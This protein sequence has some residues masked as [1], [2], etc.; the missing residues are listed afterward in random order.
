MFIREICPSQHTW[1]EAPPSHSGAFRSTGPPSVP[2]SSPGATRMSSSQKRRLQPMLRMHFQRGWIH[3]SSAQRPTCQ[4]RD[5]CGLGGFP[6]APGTPSGTASQGHVG[7]T[8]AAMMRQRHGAREWASARRDISGTPGGWTGATAS[9]QVLTPSGEPSSGLLG[10]SVE[11]VP[12]LGSQLGCYPPAFPEPL[13]RQ[14]SAARGWP[15][16]R[17]WAPLGSLWR[18][19]T[20]WPP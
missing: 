18:Q 6:S 5:H 10:Y 19:P 12:G 16:R 17:P 13:P 14:P 9:S 3:I 8:L 2:V 1:T 11:R 4:P 15:G 20:V 7:T